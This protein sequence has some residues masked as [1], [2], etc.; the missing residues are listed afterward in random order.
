MNIHI[1]FPQFIDVNLRMDCEHHMFVYNA[2]NKADSFRLAADKASTCNITFQDRMSPSMKQCHLWWNRYFNLFTRYLY[3]YWTA[4]DHSLK[5]EDKMWEDLRSFCR[6]ISVCLCVCVSVQ[7]L[8]STVLITQTCQ[9]IFRWH[10]M[11]WWVKIF[12]IGGFIN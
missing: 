2:T 1:L 8:Y 4:N 11:A 3:Y 9:S 5:V 6:Y 10:F 12:L 7:V